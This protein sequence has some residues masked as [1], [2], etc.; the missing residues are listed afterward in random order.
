M[1]HQVHAKNNGAIF[2]FDSGRSSHL[3][4][5]RV[6]SLSSRTRDLPV[7]FHMFSL[8]VYTMKL[9]DA[10]VVCY[11]HNFLQLKVSAMF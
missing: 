10:L 9:V 8:F 5:K 7:A 6:L 11:N 3:Q 1:S 4:C 2:G